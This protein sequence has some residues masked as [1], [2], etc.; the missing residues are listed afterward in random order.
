MSATAML[1]QLRE[2]YGGEAFEQARARIQA[3]TDTGR[4]PLTLRII[5]DGRE[6]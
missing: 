2:V 5:N 3:K 6:E 4:L 1:L